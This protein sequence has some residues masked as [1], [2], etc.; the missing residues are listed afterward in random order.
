MMKE[1]IIYASQNSVHNMEI[2]ILTLTP[3][4]LMVTFLVFQ[5][6]LWGVA[7]VAGTLQGY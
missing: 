5:E 3:G 4:G 1:I 2:L 7:N 6:E